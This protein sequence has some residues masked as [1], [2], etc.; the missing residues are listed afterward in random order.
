MCVSYFSNAS[1]VYMAPER[2]KLGPLGGGGREEPLPFF[3]YCRA[4]SKVTGYDEMSQHSSSQ[5]H[6]ATFV[7]QVSH[8]SR[9][10]QAPLVNSTNQ[11]SRADYMDDCV[12]D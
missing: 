10:N 8:A 3:S 4:R 5:L 7:E 6:G 12:H 2:R 9:K 1:A 11:R